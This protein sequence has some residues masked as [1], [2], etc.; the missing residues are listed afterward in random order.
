MS[1][2][3]LLADTFLAA[4]REAHPADEVELVDLK[5]MTLPPLVG[6][7]LVR[8]E[9]LLGRGETDDAE[10]ALARQ[11]AAADRIVLAAPYWELSFPAQLRLYIEYVSALNI[12]FC[13]AENGAPLGLC[14]ADKLLFLT[15]A[16]G[17]IE[18]ANCGADHLR[19]LCG[20]YGIGQF[21]FLGAPMQDVQEIDHEA[22]LKKTLAQAQALAKTF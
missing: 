18:K 11:F 3:K 15:T 16:G 7:V 12:T 1:R 5:T 10:F 8:H 19:A 17:D 20:M 14:R 21:L 2:T 22:I 9:D 4:W 13:Y 6:D